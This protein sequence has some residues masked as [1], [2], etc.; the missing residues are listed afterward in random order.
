MSTYL[1]TC[2]KVKTMSP[3]Q[4][5]DAATQLEHDLVEIAREEMGMHER[6]A[7]EIAV[8]IVRGMRKRYGGERLGSKGL[9]IPAPSKAQRNEAIRRD[10]NGNNGPEIMRRHGISR[11]RMFQIVGRKSGTANIGV[12]G[13]KV[14]KGL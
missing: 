2:P 9:Y 6:Q 3:S 5:E 13:P 7:Y 12:S 1:L 4:A 8:A 10:Y 14:P 11:S